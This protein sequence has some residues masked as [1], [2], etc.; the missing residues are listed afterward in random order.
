[1]RNVLSCSV[2]FADTG[3]VLEPRHFRMHQGVDRAPSPDDL[4]LGGLRLERIQRAAIRQTLAKAGNKAD[5]A[6][7]LGITL[8]TLNKKLKKFG[9]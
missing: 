8:S 5:A 2:A 3:T 6:R 9:I 7:M 1:L 4:P